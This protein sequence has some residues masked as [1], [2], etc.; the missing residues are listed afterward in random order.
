VFDSHHHTFNDDGLSI[1][2]AFEA[3]KETWSNG[4]KPLQHLSN[5]EPSLVNGNFM[6]RR[7]HSDMIHYI[8]DSQL[9]GLREN[10][11]DVE[12]EA[13]MKNIATA[14]MKKQFSISQ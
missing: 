2:D 3:T 12:V 11:I 8:P 13:K 14:Q 10:T 6:D 7:K 5:T 1:E 9:L 4:I